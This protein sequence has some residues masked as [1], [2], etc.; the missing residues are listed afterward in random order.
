M[1]EGAICCDAIQASI[2]RCEP[3]RIILANE[4][5][6][7]VEHRLGDARFA[8]GL[9]PVIVS[10]LLPPDRREGRRHDALN[11]VLAEVGDQAPPY[12]VVLEAISGIDHGDIA[13]RIVFRCSLTGRSKGADFEKLKQEGGSHDRLPC[14]KGGSR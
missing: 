1:S 2:V 10:A 4:V 9:G 6:G 11:G 12:R 5:A 7:R 8:A 3:L 14:G 13:Q